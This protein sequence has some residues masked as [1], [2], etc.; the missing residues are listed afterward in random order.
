[1]SKKNLGYL[2]VVFGISKNTTSE[3]F[4]IRPFSVD[5]LRV[6]NSMPHQQFVD[7]ARS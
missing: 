6:L 7:L 4:N 2:L 5:L 1:M 3:D